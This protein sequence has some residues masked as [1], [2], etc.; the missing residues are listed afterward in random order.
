V[1]VAVA[2]SPSGRAAAAA[3]IAVLP[4]HPEPA[5]RMTVSASW[6]VSGSWHGSPAGSMW[7]MMRSILRAVATV[8]RLQPRRTVSAS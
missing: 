8:A 4:Q 2:A 1:A 6:P 7:R 5:R 3:G